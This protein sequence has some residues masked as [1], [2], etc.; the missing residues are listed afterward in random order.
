[1]SKNKKKKL[2]KKQKRQAELLEKRMQEIE[3]MEKEANPGQTQPGEEE[4]A[5]TPLQMLIKVSPPEEN[6]SKKPGMDLKPCQHG[7]DSAVHCLMGVR[8]EFLQLWPF[9]LFA[10]GS[11]L[12]VRLGNLTEY[13]QSTPYLSECP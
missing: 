7:M 2:K 1:M 6:V 13:M 10:L 12:L 8:R 5:Q 4:E 3:E 9:H 11:V